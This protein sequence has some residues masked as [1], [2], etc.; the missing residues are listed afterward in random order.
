MSQ[1]HVVVIGMGYVGIPCAALLADVPGFRVTGVQRRSPR[2]AWKINCLNAGQSPFG[3]DEPGMAELIQRVV[4]EKRTLSVTDDTSVCR[5]ADVILI[6]VQTPVD[7]NDTPQY[8]DLRDATVAAGRHMRPGVLVIIESTVAPGTTQNVIQPILESESGMKAGQG[9]SLAFSYERV[10]PGKLLEFLV[11]LPRIVGGVDAASAQRAV[12]LYRHIVQEEIIATDCLSAE[13]A[14]TVENTYRDV[15]VAFANEVA[16]LCESL[17]ID[18]FE[19]RKLVNARPDRDMHLPGAGVGGHCL[20]K[21]PW[22]LKYGVARY[23][24]REVGFDLLSTARRINDSMPLHVAALVEQA[25]ARVGQPLAGAKVAVLGVA[26]LENADDTR[27]TPAVPLIR[28]LRERGAVL[29]AH[30]PYVRP[31]EYRSLGLGASAAGEQGVPYT[32][33]LA[34]A[35]QGAD[36]AVIVTRHRDYL[37]PALPQAAQAMRTRILVDGRDCLEPQACAQAGITYHGLGRGQTL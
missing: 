30:D 1:T 34:Q 25:L 35:L 18:V 14:K 32:Q 6:D 17:G 16:L 21:D 12:E 37:G 11:Y 23:G 27:N 29:T 33:D 24:S 31:E 28:A 5:D 20:P 15:N 7:H 26:Y 36:C 8:R 10:M 13:T 19:V 22:L 2:S 9:F 3:G 4:L